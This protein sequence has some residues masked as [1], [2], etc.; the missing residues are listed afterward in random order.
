ME[1]EPKGESVFGGEE[2]NEKGTEMGAGDT[3]VPSLIEELNELPDNKHDESI[4]IKTK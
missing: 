2:V 1:V 4:C 3:A